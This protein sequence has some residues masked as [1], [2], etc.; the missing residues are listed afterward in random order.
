MNALAD[1]MTLDYSIEGRGKEE[2]PVLIA[3]PTGFAAVAVK[4]VTLHSLLKLEVE[5]NKMDK[6]KGNYLY[7]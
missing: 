7:F 6:Y 4:G 3:A 2:P 5:K 1:R